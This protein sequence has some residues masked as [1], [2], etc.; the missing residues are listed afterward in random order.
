MGQFFQS[1]GGGSFAYSDIDGQTEDTTP[2]IG[3]FVPTAD[4]SVSGLKKVTL[5]NIFKVINGLTQDSSPD[6]SADYVPTW[7]NSASG[8]KKVAPV[9]FVIAA[10]ASQAEQ[11]TGTATNRIVTP[12]RQQYHPSAGKAWVNCSQ[13]GTNNGSYN[14]SSISNSATGDNTINFTTNF[15]SGTYSVAGSGGLNS[16]SFRCICVNVTQS[17]SQVRLQTLDVDGGSLRDGNQRAMMM[18][19]Q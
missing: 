11:E 12:G 3:D 1:G 6:I 7:D 10:A 16:T 15:S 5:A 2:A 9:D 17:T 18:G 4:I 19:D 14:V 8:P 13:S